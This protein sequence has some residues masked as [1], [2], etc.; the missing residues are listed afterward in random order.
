MPLPNKKDSPFSTKEPIADKRRTFR[1]VAYMAFFSFLCMIGGIYFDFIRNPAIQTTYYLIKTDQT[2]E[3]E[4]LINPQPPQNPITSA[5]QAPLTDENAH[6]IKQLEKERENIEQ[7]AEILREIVEDSAETS[8]LKDVPVLPET[9]ELQ[10]LQQEK[11]LI[12]Q[13]KFE[14]IE[15]LNKERLK[16]EQQ[17]A[18]A[19]NNVAVVPQ[20]TAPSLPPQ[21]EKSAAPAPSVPQN[22]PEELTGKPSEYL[23]SL[24]TELPPPDL[25]QTNLMTSLP[26]FSLIKKSISQNA[27]PLHIIEPLPELQEKAATVCFPL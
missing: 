16:Q 7:T 26:D 27:I 18:A 14:E 20:D 1:I 11:D 24:R 19:V 15:N 8:E 2:L 13:K 6:L 21:E 5:E 9:P 22:I 10:K 23:S 3:K 25:I 4:T 12:D 17:K